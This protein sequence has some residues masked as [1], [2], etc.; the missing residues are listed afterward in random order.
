MATPTRSGQRTANTTQTGISPC[1]AVAV[2]NALRQAG[3]T[4]DIV[5]SGFTDARYAELPELPDAERGAL[6]RRVDILIMPT[7]GGDR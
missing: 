5:A 4:E 2:A 1:R 6:G 7:V 3:Y